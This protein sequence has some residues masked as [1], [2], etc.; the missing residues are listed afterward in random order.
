MGYDKFI[1]YSFSYIAL[2]EAIKERL[3]EIVKKNAQLAKDMHDLGTERDSK[4]LRSRIKA[5][6]D[7]ATL[8]CKEIK[9]AFQLQTESNSSAQAASINRM[10]RQFE[11]EKKKTMD[12]ANVYAQKEAYILRRSEELIDHNESKDV[13]AEKQQRLEKEEVNIQVLVTE[14]AELEDR[15]EKLKAIQQDVLQLKELMH[16]MADIV[17]A[18]QESIDIVEKNAAMM[19]HHTMKAEEQIQQASGLQEKR[20]IIC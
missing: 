6:I 4:D 19:N 10:A 7:S 14:V 15:Q 8:L 1:P 12:M 2:M 16:D 3:L 17:A 11:G 13:A 9:V 18:Q 5:N 20:C